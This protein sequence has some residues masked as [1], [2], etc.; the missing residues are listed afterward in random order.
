[1]CNPIQDIF[2]M[3]LRISFD[4]CPIDIYKGLVIFK[5]LPK[6]RFKLVLGDWNRAILLP[7]ILLPSEVN[8][9]IKKRCSKRYAIRAFSSSGSKM[10]FTLLT[11]VVAFH[12]GLTTIH[13]W[14][15]SFQKLFTGLI[16]SRNLSFQDCFQNLL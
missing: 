11:Q 12:V 7:F 13:V 2:L 3:V 9:V 10:V 4:L 6:K 1:M 8:T 14:E 15:P 5:T 16:G